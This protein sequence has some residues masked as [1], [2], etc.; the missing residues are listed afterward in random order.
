MG[1]GKPIAPADE[2]GD[3][4]PNGGGDGAGAGEPIVLVADDCAGH[5]AAEP[6]GGV[7]DK[8]I[9]TAAA[10]GELMPFTGVEDAI[11]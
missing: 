4:N 1:A 6:K 5:A 11:D 9:A 7:A 8:S 10:G 3:P 2:R